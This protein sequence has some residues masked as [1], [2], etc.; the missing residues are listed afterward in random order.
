MSSSWM[1]HRRY[2]TDDDHKSVYNLY[3]MGKRFTSHKKKKI[4]LEIKIRKWK[5]KKTLWTIEQTAV[6]YFI[7]WNKTRCTDSF[8]Q[9]TNTQR[10]S[11]FIFFHT[12]P[13]PAS[14]YLSSLVLEDWAINWRISKSNYLVLS[15]SLKF[16]IFFF[17]KRRQEI[18]L[19]YW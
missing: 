2:H 16:V 17:F 5:T 8:L 10:K 13:V 6:Q 3:M 15:P 11:Y 14:S 9:R 19:I 4:M 7:E 18:C 1:T 12:S